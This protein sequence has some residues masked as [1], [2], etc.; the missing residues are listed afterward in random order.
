ME[1]RL[2]APN[3]NRDGAHA[4]LAEG[5]ERHGASIEDLRKLSLEL[6]KGCAVFVAGSIIDGNANLY[7]DVDL[8]A[9]TAEGVP[10]DTQIRRLNTL[11]VDI[12]MRPRSEFLRLAR[13]FDHAKNLAQMHQI[14]RDPTLAAVYRLL[15]AFPLF[16]DNEIAEIQS[17]LPCTLFQ[18]YLIR[19]RCGATNN[20]LQDSVGALRTDDLEYAFLRARDAIGHS[21]EAAL[22]LSGDL[23]PMSKY[24]V[25]RLLRT[26]G[27]EHPQCER[28]IRYNSSWPQERQELIRQTEAMV[29]DAR[30]TLNVVERELWQSPHATFELTAVSPHHPDPA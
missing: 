19:H 23:N 21:S 24:L 22:A 3:L 20:D 28:F 17:S 10:L 11:R 18:L 16:G 7:S 26:F 8:F 30:R 5:L 9:V 25:K 13:L 29:R 6:C 15:S 12:E 4:N 1:L 2:T 27:A 14:Y